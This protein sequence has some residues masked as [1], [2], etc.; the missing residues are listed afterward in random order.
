M[1][2]LATKY[3]A[4]WFL[5]IFGGGW[6][7]PLG[8]PPA[9]EYPAWHA[10]AGKMPLLCQLGRHG[11][12]GSQ[13]QESNRT[14]AGR[15]R[16]PTLACRAGGL[17]VPSGVT[18]CCR[19]PTPR[20]TTARTGRPRWSLPRS[21]PR[22]RGPSSPR[23]SS[24]VRI[25]TA[26]RRIMRHVRSR[27]PGRRQAL[28]R[29]RRASQGS[30]HRRDGPAANGQPNLPAKKPTVGSSNRG[31]YLVSFHSIRQRAQIT[32]GF[33]GT[34]FILG[35]GDGSVEEIL[36]RRRQEPP[37][38]LVDSRKQLPVER[39]STVVYLNL[40]MLLDEMTADEAMP[41]TGEALRRLGLDKLSAVQ[42]VSGLDGETFTSKMLL[43]TD[44]EP[45]GPLLTLFSDQPLRAEDLKPIPRD[46]TLAFAMRFDA[47]K[48]VDQFA[49]LVEQPENRPSG[50]PWK[51]RW[52]PSR[53]RWSRS[54]PRPAQGPGR[55]LLHLHF[56]RRRRPGVVGPHGRRA[57]PGPRRG[58]CDPGEAP[59]W[60]FGQEPSGRV[61]H[62]PRSSCRSR[63][64]NHSVS[65]ASGYFTS[66]RAYGHRLSR[67][68]S[69]PG[70]PRTAS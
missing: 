40:K 15:T 61:Q 64:C 41:K 17:L 29:L 8:L 51:G 9:P 62:G 44:G 52:T 68:S 63:G 20:T 67:F 55:H 3:F 57:D 13:E 6:T 7:V 33:D 37:A 60:F 30:N 27:Q 14:T 19:P 54:P 70:A 43:S 36:N 18:S 48:V 56:A 31:P 38:W 59:H 42:S 22:T 49:A 12:G 21:L 5:T 2:T 69:P 50:R 66:P 28:R 25:R 16:S 39:M 65:R 26:R 32:C 45:Q 1:E 53:R 11:H 34:D 46:A 4:F 23:K 47:Q 58:F 35:V 10:C 24:M